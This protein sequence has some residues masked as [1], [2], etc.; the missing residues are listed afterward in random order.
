M[1]GMRDTGAQSIHAPLGSPEDS[2]GTDRSAEETVQKWKSALSEAQQSRRKFE[3]IWKEGLDYYNGKHWSAPRPSY[4]SSHKSNFIF[5]T[6]E[7]I[8]PILTDKSPTI[9]FEPRGRE[10]EQSAK[11]VEDIVRY[12]WD[13][14]DLDVMLTRTCRPALILGSHLVKVTFDPT[15]GPRM[16]GIPLGDVKVRDIPA[17]ALF[18]DP[19]ATTFENAQYMIHK[20]DIPVITALTRYPHMRAAIMEATGDED[21]LRKWNADAISVAGQDQNRTYSGYTLTDE[22]ATP[23]TTGSVYTPFP[24]MTASSKTVCILEC[25]YR[26]EQGMNV[27]TIVGNKLESNRPNPYQDGKYPFAIFRDYDRPGEFWGRGEPEELVSL[28]KTMNKMMANITDNASLMANGIWKAVRGSVDAAKLVNQPGLVVTYNPGYDP[29]QREPGVALPGFVT[30]F[31]EMLRSHFDTVSGVHDVTQGRGPSGITAGVAIES[32]QEAAHTRIRLKIRGLEAF[33]AQVGRLMLS[34]IQQFYTEERIIRITNVEGAADFLR[35]APENIQGEFDVRATAGASL[36]Q[37]QASR[38]QQ[39]ILLSDRISKIDPYL[40]VKVALK[41]SEYP[42]REALIAEID[43][44]KAK[45]EQQQAMAQQQQAEMQAQQAQ[46]AQGGQ[47]APT[48]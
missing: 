38:F 43:G 6:I 8:L 14:Q 12:L 7:T 20:S 5:A 45:A 17:T 16:M 26:T 4:R 22:G 37:T 39:A 27:C 32:L 25:W 34:R 46:M 40:A 13:I 24:D 3:A 9:H 11:I 42:E 10:D 35:V 41:A 2:Y 1:I 28:Q 15:A 29:P 19:T 21:M 30:Q 48:Q 44:L 23:S 36:A 18:P 31:V 47:G 33:L